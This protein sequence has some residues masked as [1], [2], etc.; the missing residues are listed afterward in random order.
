MGR[1]ARLFRDITPDSCGCPF[2]GGFEG[3]VLVYKAEC[4]DPSLGFARLRARI[5]DLRM[6]VRPY[7]GPPFRKERGRVGHPQFCHY[8][9]DPSRPCGSL[10]MTSR[11]EKGRPNVERHDVRMGHPRRTSL[12]VARFLCFAQDDN[13]LFGLDSDSIGPLPFCDFPSSRFPFQTSLPFFATFSAHDQCRAAA[14]TPALGLIRRRAMCRRRNL[15]L[16]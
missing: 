12:Q 3:I 4:R 6:T 16:R 7:H 2:G 15:S 1:T 10:R 14:P 8:A 5:R 13:F 9:L 11:A